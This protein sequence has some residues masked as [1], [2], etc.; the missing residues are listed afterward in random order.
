MSNPSL[1]SS[2]LTKRKRI[3]SL[4]Q[5]QRQ[6]KSL[7]VQ[8][9]HHLHLPRCTNFQ[10]LTHHLFYHQE[11]K[12]YNWSTARKHLGMPFSYVWPLQNKAIFQLT[13]PVSAVRTIWVT[14]YTTN[15]KTQATLGCETTHLKPPLVWCC[16]KHAINWTCERQQKLK[17]H[18]WVFLNHWTSQ[19]RKMQRHGLKKD[20]AI[21]R[22][23]QC[24]RWITA[25]FRNAVGPCMDFCVH[26]LDSY[27]FKVT[28]QLKNRSFHFPWIRI[29][30]V[31]VLES[32]FISM[33]VATHIPI[34]ELEASRWH[35]SRVCVWYFQGL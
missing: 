17:P 12:L 35:N 31:Y 25:N 5:V 22:T 9:T 3:T 19:P 26:V 1:S 11:F 34:S 21:F 13:T 32:R 15:F 27:L 14:A 8:Q 18:H 23:W 7:A 29:D 2:E 28:S 4:P 30:T 24:Y 10:L 33:D 6:R 20:G 16:F